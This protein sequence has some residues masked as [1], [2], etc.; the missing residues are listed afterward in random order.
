MKSS[1]VY[2]PKIILE[3]EINEKIEARNPFENLYG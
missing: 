2:R 1:S 3:G